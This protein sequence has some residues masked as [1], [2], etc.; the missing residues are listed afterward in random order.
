M[1]AFRKSHP[2]IGRSRFWREDICWYGV[3]GPPDTGADS[4]GFAYCLRGH[5]VNDDDLYVM[6]NS[7]WHTLD[8]VIQDQTAAPWRL[9]LN[10]AK[11]TPDDILE[12]DCWTPLKSSTIR[13]EARS[14]VLLLRDLS[15]AR[16]LR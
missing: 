2:S 8:F 6:I 12:D 5:S 7:W 15:R 13:V 3:N 11:N 10:T 1:I 9:V 4:H 14:V 16:F